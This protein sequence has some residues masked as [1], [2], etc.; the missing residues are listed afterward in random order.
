M[1]RSQADEIIHKAQICRLAMAVNNQPYVVPLSFGYDGRAIYFHTA[2]EGLKIDMMTANP[3]VCF[4]VE[5]DVQLRKSFNRGCN[6]SFTYESV[7]GFGVV[8]EL[9]S[10]ADKKEALRYILKHYSGDAGWSLDDAEVNKTRV[11]KL[12]IERLSAKKST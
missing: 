10:D 1:D 7:I 11:W 12:V 9:I 2:L 4:E 6:W 5:A 8:E 3:H